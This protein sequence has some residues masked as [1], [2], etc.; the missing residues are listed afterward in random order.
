MNLHS[1][2]N[3][4]GLQII[5]FLLVGGVGFVVDAVAL[6]LMVHGAGM[7]P[8]WSRIPSLLIALTVTWWLH[9]SFTFAWARGTSPSGSEWLRFVIVNGFGNALNLSIYWV[10]V[11]FLAWGILLSLT[12]ASI[13]AAGINYSMSARWVFRRD[14]ETLPSSAPDT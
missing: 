14:Q 7:S 6:L 9:R 3:R 2:V 5:R 10:L 11:G 12:I 8:I 1:H 4:H 13:L